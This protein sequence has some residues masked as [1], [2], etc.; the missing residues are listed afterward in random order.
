MLSASH[1]LWTRIGAGICLFMVA[2]QIYALWKMRNQVAAGKFW[3]RTSGKII[4]S[5]LSQP[6]VPR[7]G[8]ETD[9]TVD[10]HY[11]YQVGG[12]SFEGKRIKFRG[13]GGMAQFAA[14]QLVAKYPV[15][16]AVEVYYD[17]KAPTH[18]ALEPRNKGNATPHIVFL[19][20]FTIFSAVLIAHSV[21]GKVLTNANGVPL[22]AFTLPLFAIM[23]GIGA[24]VQYFMLRRQ[25]AASMKWPTVS[26]KVTRVS[27]VAE[28]RQ[29]DGDDGRNRITT[30]YRPDVQYSYAVGGREFHSSA[31]K[32]GW[33][34]LYP[35]EESAKAPA[36]KYTAGANV[37]VFY[38]PEIPEQAILEP[39]NKDGTA[40][41]IVFGAMFALTGAGMFWVFW[42]MQV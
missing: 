21:A 31:W 37:P 12:K 8:D 16:A 20:V 19:I 27:V 17:P 32:W 39:G 1:L 11:Q 26:G 14:E 24:F 9:T 2:N 18:S 10:I 6:D 38:N 41:Q 28:E 25:G 15:G 40:A 36:A 35:D 22:F 34:A 4:T 42:G 33:T 29:E 30:V 5:T 7:K 13:Q 3:S 23:V